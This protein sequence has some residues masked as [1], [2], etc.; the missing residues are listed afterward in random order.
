VTRSIDVFL[1]GYKP[2]RRSVYV[3]QRADLLEEQGRLQKAVAVAIRDDMSSNKGP[4]APKLRS[5][6]SQ[7]E[8]EIRESEFEFTFEALGSQEYTKLKA[9]HPP[10]AKDR[11]NRLDFNSDTFPQR[12]IAACCVE[13]E[14][15]AEQAEQ[16]LSTL[17]EGQV[18]K[19]WNCA[20]AVNVGADDAPK[21]VMPSAPADSSETSS[22]TADPEG[23]LA[24]SSSDGS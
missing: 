13:P 21:S 14:I 16:L 11:K 17:T 23:S 2:P 12:L 4:T 19:L 18:T 3:T 7:I 8:D 9:A 22:S 15:S 1:G 20:I 24:A 6:L 10:S 5:E